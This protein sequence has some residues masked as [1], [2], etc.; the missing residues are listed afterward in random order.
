[1]EERIFD[2]DFFARLNKINLNINLRLSNGM[3]GGRKSKA[4][5]ASVEFSD[6]REYTYGDDFRRI[7]WNAYGRFDKLFIKIF[8]EERE[9]I[10]NL[11]LDKSKSMDFGKKS[12]KK[13]ALQVLGALSYIAMNNLDRV[14]INIASEENLS[15]LPSSNG[16]KG[17]QMLLKELEKIEFSGK[18]ELSKAICKRKINNKGVSIVVSDFFYNEGV[19]SLEEGIKYLAYKKQQIVLIQVLCEEEENPSLEEE[20]TLIDSETK[21]KIK[22]NLNYKMIQAY[23]DEL[24]KY[25]ERLEKLVMKYGGILVTVNTSK[26]IEEIILNDFGK[27]KIIY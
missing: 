6:F 19:E 24:K 20:V 3:Q 15:L 22:L 8:M 1:M 5:G 14:Y 11:F 17:F 18:T 16:K 27:K 25:N 9:G 4:K 10:F 21:E 12:K 23:K 2:D 26:S 13:T 7:D